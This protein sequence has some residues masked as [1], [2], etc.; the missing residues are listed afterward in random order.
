MT[1][2]VGCCK[3]SKIQIDGGSSVN[4]LYGHTLNRME[5]TPEQGRK[6]INPR[7]QSLLYDFDESKARSPSTVEFSVRA[8]LFNIAQSYV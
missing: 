5:D 6:M 3:V 8:K 1:V 4:I 2:H 7:T